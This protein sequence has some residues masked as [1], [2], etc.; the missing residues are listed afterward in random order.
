MYPPYHSFR[1]FSAKTHCRCV[2]WSRCD[3]TAIAPC[4]LSPNDKL[5]I[6]EESQRGTE[7]PLLKNCV[8]VHT[9]WRRSY[10]SSD[11]PKERKE[12]SLAA[13]IPA[14]RPPLLS[15]CLGSSIQ[16]PITRSCHADSGLSDNLP[17]RRIIAIVGID[18]GKL[19]GRYRNG[20]NESGRGKSPK[21]DCAAAIQH[22]QKAGSQGSVWLTA[23]SICP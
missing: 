15:V 13:T 23:L 19:S 5:L 7:P 4:L 10:Q 16:N 14:P 9:W 11:S 3:V 20:M 22:P 2:P 1:G 18:L 12:R 17:R 8:C 21:H 6:D